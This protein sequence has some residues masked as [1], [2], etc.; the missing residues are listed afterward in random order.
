MFVMSVL[1]CNSV[2]KI[3]RIRN[4]EIE[5]SMS[6]P[7]DSV[8]EGEEKEQEADIDSIRGTLQEGPMI[9]TAIRDD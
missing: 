4:G 6:L 1:S 3:Q 8:E 9:M 7:D 5:V 2:R